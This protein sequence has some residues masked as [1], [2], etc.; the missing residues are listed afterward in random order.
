MSK[1]HLARIIETPN[2]DGE[3]TRALEFEDGR[4]L[5]FPKDRVAVADG[6]TLYDWYGREI[7]ISENIKRII[8]P[9]GSD[10]NGGSFF[11]ANETY[12]VEQNNGY[13]SV[14][15]L[16]Y[17]SASL[18]TKTPWHKLVMTGEGL[19]HKMTLA[20]DS[21]YVFTQEH[22]ELYATPVFRAFLR[23]ME[24]PN[25]IRVF[26]GVKSR[27]ET[28]CDKTMS[29]FYET[30]VRGIFSGW[31][32]HRFAESRDELFVHQGANWAEGLP[33]ASYVIGDLTI[34]ENG[35]KISALSPLW[36]DQGGNVRISTDVEAIEQIGQSADL[37]WYKD[38]Q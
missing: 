18:P 37:C 16:K 14:A 2:E 22:S 17:M 5:I 27:D 24:F 8:G 13:M 36:N 15:N 21:R 29:V 20:I 33:C 31:Y 38:P 7:T 12:L 23:N 10:T 28:L 34:S 6:D 11:R 3:F 19:A 35:T 32:L 1:P 4:K 9:L 30:C 26:I 25:E